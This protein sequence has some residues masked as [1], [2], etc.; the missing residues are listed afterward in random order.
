MRVTTALWRSIQ[1]LGLAP[2]VL[3]A[4]ATA[5]LIWLVAIALG[6]WAVLFL[7]PSVLVYLA[8][9]GGAFV[10]AIGRLLLFGRAEGLQFIIP[11]I[12][13]LPLVLCCGFGGMRAAQLLNQHVLHMPDSFLRE[14]RTPTT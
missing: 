13:A 14:D 8:V 12:C 2:L 9:F 4:V 7:G 1:Q 6:A 10:S 11:M 3:I 5:A